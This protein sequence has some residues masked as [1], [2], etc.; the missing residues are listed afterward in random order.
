MSRTT[1]PRLLRAEWTKFRTVRGWVLG[2]AAAALATVLVGLLGTAAPGPSGQ[3]TDTSFPR[4]PGGEAVNDNFFLVHRTL[5]GDGSI[6]VPVQALTGV[7]DA[8]PTPDTGRTTDTT[9]QTAGDPTTADVPPSSPAAVSPWAKAGIIVKGSLAQGSTYAAVMVTGAHG[10]RMQY[11]YTGDIAAAGSSG[12]VS[13]GSARW[14]RLV[15]AG[16]LL[17]G[18]VSADGSHWSWVGTARLA[19]L[20]ATVQAGLFVASPQAME[21]TPVGAGFSPAVARG[22]FGRPVLGGDWSDEDWTGTQVGDDAGTSGSYTNTTK[23]EFTSS[24]AGFSVTGAGDI[25]PVVGGPAMGHGYT[26][27]NFL[28]GAFAGLIVV[29]AVGTV[30]VTAEYR[31]GLI[32]TTLT[33]HPGRGRVLVA[34]AAVVAAAAFAVGLVAAAVAVPLGGRSAEGRGFRVFPVPTATELRVVVGTA[35]LFAVTAVLALGVGAVLRRSA[36]AVALVV[37]SLVLPYLL[38]TAGVLPVGASEWL[39]RVTPAAGFAVQQ[40]LPRYAQVVTVYEP[41]TGY[42]PLPPWAGFAVLCGYAAVAFALAL[43]RMKRRDA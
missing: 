28:V 1:F 7:P 41:S 40:T 10:V 13:E 5:T 32:R 27:E 20:P 26:L 21:E 29:T 43:T 42:H 17:T 37:A 34:K 33:A 18:Y 39:L 11:D 12:G 9:P 8:G 14:L 38:A 36:T 19:G 30:F 6:T 2:M 4:G 22:D 35:L 3:G 31:R 16:S 23:G 15:R 24:A 25:A